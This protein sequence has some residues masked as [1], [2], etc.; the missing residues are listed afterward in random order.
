MSTINEEVEKNLHEERIRE[1]ELLEK[2]RPAWHLVT[3]KVG[4]QEELSF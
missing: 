3:A 4:K 2:A 1:S